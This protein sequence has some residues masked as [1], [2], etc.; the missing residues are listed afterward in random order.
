MSKIQPIANYVL[1]DSNSVGEQKTAGGI[2]IPDTAAEKPQDGVIV[3]VSPEATDQIEVGDKVVYKQY[4][5]TQITH[6]GKDLLL[7][8]D[9]D[10]LA[11]YVEV[12]EV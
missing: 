2:I 7:V 3:A 11:K 5:G 6:D 12:D 4:S 10:I 1:I 8:P 9:S